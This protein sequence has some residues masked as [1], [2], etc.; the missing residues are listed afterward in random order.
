MAYFYKGFKIVERPDGSFAVIAPAIGNKLVKLTKSR[1]DA[2]M[3]IEKVETRMD[4]IQ[5]SQR[6]DKILG[7]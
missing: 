5:A 4:L 3:W 1:I 6:V 7:L 2:K